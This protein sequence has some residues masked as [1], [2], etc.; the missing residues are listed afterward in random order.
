MT[1]R[2]WSQAPLLAFAI[3]ATGIY[4]VAVSTARRIPTLDKP[5]VVAIGV[6]LDLTVV[7]PA[8]YYWLAVRRGGWPAATLPS[9]ILLSLAGAALV[10][11][12]K[13]DLLEVLAI[14]AELALLAWVAVRT[15]QS[16]R[17]LDGAVEDD[18]LEWLRAVL[19]EILPVR[20]VADVFAFEMAVLYYALLSWR[21]PSASSSEA[22]FT[23]HRKSG[24]GGIVFALLLMMLVEAIP[25]HL[26]LSRWSP[27]AA[28]VLTGL[29]LYG[30]LWF[31]G[32]Y[33]AARLRPILL[34]AESLRVRTG[35]R[36]SLR[37]PREQVVAV[38]KK[39]MAGARR[40]RMAL[41][42]TSMLWIELAE[43]VTV[44]GPYGF[45][46]RAQCVGVAVDEPDRFL[47]ALER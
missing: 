4:A 30:M 12:G 38:H 23:Y 46:R 37:I 34:D 24:Y 42:G 26:L 2:L 1:R 36:W 33:R 35:M 14:P 5:D 9:I 10:L 7:I 32:D 40:L 27:A 8:A 16:I 6:L 31:I 3:L 22:V 44:Q 43:P 20:R 25:V 18:V 15:R 13:R 45:E 19:R 29:T 39:S 11:P 47:Q 17:R 41:P 28:W 21:R